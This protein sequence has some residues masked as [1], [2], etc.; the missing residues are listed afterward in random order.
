MHAEPLGL[1]GTQ[2]GNLCPTH[3]STEV[4]TAFFLDFLTDEYGSDGLSRNVKLP[5]ALRKIPEERGYHVDGHT[6][7]V[8]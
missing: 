2:V 5:T 1:H 8:S 4:S 3:M 7:C 6:R